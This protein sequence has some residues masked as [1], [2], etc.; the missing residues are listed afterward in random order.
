MLNQAVLEAMY[1]VP[2]VETYLDIVENLPDEI[3][4]Y[5]TKIRELDVLYQSYMKE[6]EHIASQNGNKIDQFSR[7]RNLLRVQVALIAAQEI[8]DEKLSIMQQ[9][10]DVIEGKTRQIDGIFYNLPSVTSRRE[11]EAV[12]TSV[13]HDE[14]VSTEKTQ[15]SETPVAPK[16]RQRKKNTEVDSE[17]IECSSTPLPR[18]SATIAVV[19]KPSTQSGG[20]KKK[21]KTKQQ[22]E[23]EKEAT[24][25][26]DEDLAIDPNEPTYCLCN[27]VS[28]G[29][30]V[31]C[32]NDLCPH[33]W[34]HFSCVAVTNTP[35]G[36]WYC[37]NCRK[38]RSNAVRPKK[39]LVERL[40]KYNKE[41]QEKIG[42][43]SK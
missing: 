11:Q 24:P 12:E 13:K 34:F 20:K 10:Q 9:V 18:S 33:Q 4:R 15:Q 21:R 17:M 23:C 6:I 3:Q 30:M 2:Y 37:P 19:K 22:R 8:G 32:D 16:K 7:K 29:Q 5:L 38:A 39:Q 28:F 40:E 43:M 14:A 36:K 1:S 42:N 27:Q 31:M 41:K 35:K 26:P 25:P